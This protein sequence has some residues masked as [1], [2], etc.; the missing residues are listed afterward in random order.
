MQFAKNAFRLSVLAGL[1]AFSCGAQAVLDNGEM[2]IVH[3][4]QWTYENIDKDCKEVLGPKGYDGIQISQPAEHIDKRGEGNPWWAVYQPVNFWNFTT[5]TGNETQLRNM[6]KACNEAGVKVF[7][8]AVFNQR[9]SGSGTGLGGS[10]F[11][12]RNYPDMNYDDF[13]DAHCNGINYSNAYEIQFCDLSGM[14]DVKTESDS[15]R[16]KIA[17]YLKN[18]MSMGVYGF[19]IDAAKHMKPEDIA[20]ILSKAGNPPAYMEVIGA[21]GQ[22]VQPTQYA[23]IPNSVVTEFKYCDVMQKNIYNPQ[24]LINLN[25]SW[26]QLPG[27]A[28]EVFI[29]NHDNERGSAGTSFLT[30]QNNGWAF[31]L[32]QS[33]MVAY[34]YGTVRQIYSGYE[35]HSHD[36]GGPIGSDRCTG[37]WHCE[38]R[39]S[40]V[41]NAVGFARATRGESVSSKGAEGKLI[42]FNRGKKGFY[43]LNA[44]DNEV[45]KEFPVTVPDGQYCE[46]LQQDDKCGGQQITV[47]GGKAVIR[48]P[49][50][51]A[52]AICVDSSGKGF[53]GGAAVDPC[54]ADP[55]SKA[56][57]C[58]KTPD[59]AVCV[60]DRYYAGTSNSWKFTKMNYDAST[61]AWTL[62]LNLTG[63]GDKGG[64]QRFKIT[65]QDNWKGTVWGTKD[66]KNL[67][68]DQVSCNDVEIEGKKGDYTLVIGLDNTVNLVSSGSLIASFSS[69]VDGLTARFNNTTNGSDVSYQWDFGDGQ[70]SSETNPTHTYSKSGNYTV[71]L[72][73]TKNNKSVTARSSVSVSGECQPKL[74]SLYYAGSSNSWKHQPFDFNSES[75]RWEISVNLTGKSDTGGSQRFKVTDTSG[76]NGTVWGQGTGNTLCSN[77][78]TCGDVKISQ[79]GQYVLWV[80]DADMSYGLDASSTENHA[81]VASFDAVVDGLT[82][83]LTSTSKDA[84][85]DELDL[86]WNLGDGTTAN[87]SVVTHSYGSEGE[88][89]V[90]LVANDGKVDSAAASKKVKVSTDVI[91]ANHDA[92]YFAGT[93]NK[94]THDAMTYDSTTGNWSIDLV[95]SGEGDGNGPQRF[96]ITDKKGWTGNVWGDAGSNALCNNQASCGDIQ[97]DEVGNYTLYIN[98]ADMTWS[99]ESQG[100]FTATHSAM[101]YAGTTNGWTHEPMT[102]DSETGNWYIDLYLTGDSDSN[103]AQRFK[104]TDSPNWKGTVWG[105]GSGNSLCSNQSSCKDVKVSEVGNYRLSVN[106]KKLTWTLTAN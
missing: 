62:A 85:N 99:L 52:A 39:A 47:S 79:V 8:D 70:G 78:A 98:D 51:S 5:M 49:A 24:Y 56:C 96:K 40:I 101:Y 94:W 71:T 17:N 76:W 1:C 82:V 27:Y 45:T 90:S 37:G 32:A 6:I 95:L 60:A 63:E 73:A 91:H 42:W 38:H 35:F 87:G 28:S 80:K 102:F 54:D 104:V 26:T 9:A 21:D 86:E 97:I 84:D 15:T 18:L 10:Q 2:I 89:T 57:V 74:S 88:Y 34:P 105:Q 31:Q 29:A 66:G 16:T 20:S 19:R 12:N 25:D 3:P 36:Q 72:T 43:A 41:N 67:C 53:C 4:F 59:A 50:H 93:A 22:P 61:K 75:C 81:P 69:Q 14:P 103:G 23:G 46:I 65:D 44:G 30:Y 55:G 77:Q 7:A 68:S 106:D 11:S 13:H 58:K 64:V 83:T 48:V 33:F 92:L 100:G